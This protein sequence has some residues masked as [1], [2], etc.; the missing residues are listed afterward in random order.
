MHSEYVDRY[1]SAFEELQPRTLDRLVALFGEN[2]RFID[3]FNDVR[4]RAAIR[5]IF[6][7][8]FAHCE[9]PQFCVEEAIGQDETWYLRWRFT[10]GC[11]TR[12]RVIEGVSRVCFDAAG[13]VSEHIDYWDP[14]AQLYEAIPLLGGILRALRRRLG[15]PPVRFHTN[16]PQDTSSATVR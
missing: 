1:V 12:Q 3:P 8:M 7:H 4:G 13:L 15:R 2:A 6:E 9:A 11:N 14:A 10:F 5:G 16:H